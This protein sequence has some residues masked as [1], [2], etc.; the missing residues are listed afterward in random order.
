MKSKKIS[1][2]LYTTIIFMFLFQ[3]L[4]CENAQGRKKTDK[5]L[6]I[7]SYSYNWVSVPKQLKGFSENIN[8]YT[9]TDYIFMDT[10]EF[11]YSDIKI[12]TDNQVEKKLKNS[13]DYEVIVVG[14][15]NALD[16]VLERQEKYFL[17]KPIVF[18]GINDIEKGIQ[19]SKDPLITGVLEKYYCKS[20][21]DIAKEI[22][23]FGKR[24]VAIVDDT[25]T[26][27]GSKNQLIRALE[28]FKNMSISYINTSQLTFEEIQKKLSNLKLGE[29]I[30]IF[31]NFNNDREGNSYNV[32]QASTIIS[33]NSSVP[34]FRTDTGIE[35]GLLGG[36]IIDFEE[37]GD[38]AAL[39][40]NRILAGESAK[41]IDV[42]V[43]E[44][45][46][47]INYEVYKKFN[48]KLKDEIKDK[49]NFINKP[50][51]FLEEHSISIIYILL[52]IIAVF[53]IL[54]AINYYNNLEKQKELTGKA[55]S[56]NK[57]KSDF[58]ANMSHEIRTPM[59]SIIGL[60]E[61]INIELK[62]NKNNKVKEYLKIIQ[63]S[64]SLLLKLINNVLDISAIETNKIKLSIEQF[65]IREIESYIN[66][67]YLYQCEKKGIN[68]NIEY[69][70]IVNE[71][72]K[73]DI[74]RIN[75]VL[76]NL[77]SNSYKFTEKG[78]RIDLKISE[79]KRET[80]EIKLKFMI[81]DTGCGMSEEL[82]DRLFH[83]FEQESCDTARRYGG[84]GLGL[85]I[86][87][88]MIELMGGKIKVKSV[89]DK[90]TIFIVEL[91]LEE[92]NKIKEEKSSIDYVT[93]YNFSG[94]KILVAEDNEINAMIIRKILEN[95]GIEVEVAENGK[96][97]HNKFMEKGN[98]YFD[99][100]LMD[101]KMP[102]V[103]GYDGTKLIRE[104]KLD[105]SKKIKIYAMTADAFSETVKRCLEAGMNGHISKPITP[106]D[107]Y[108]L[109]QN[110]L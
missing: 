106:K 77:I 67:M 81:K 38:K 48:L 53:S 23:P 35:F 97:A 36:T 78:G 10:K 57:A 21:L 79:Y 69:T 28:D 4:Y 26:S 87:K 89:K 100:I 86:T 63:E 74:F 12:D 73:G 107:L 103:D 43:C 39:M 94:K 6:F 32:K 96:I 34:V 56:E 24:V 30:L 16:Y 105:Y 59:S 33:K 93:K 15:D 7:S 75:Q 46:T 80:G 101:I 49:I 44:P 66:N 27:D 85:S 82:K 9:E 88:S 1:L 41:D 11:K 83:K 72:L 109:L 3:I 70:N 5:I 20:T 17:N 13:K 19:A 62:D 102:E 71:Q 37:M 60:T 2:K 54:M 51:S 18:L 90:G 68:L 108:E 40:V 76:L 29:D 65:N 50:K 55:E 47:V 110:M 31:F 45:K 22:F 91:F 104:S 92:G 25:K 14:D 58:L 84:S 99:L 8:D 95:V 98:K 64:S 42:Q 61:L 52:L